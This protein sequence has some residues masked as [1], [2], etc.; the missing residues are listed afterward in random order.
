MPR[1]QII[2]EQKILPQKLQRARELR[3]EMTPEERLLWEAVRRNQLG[4]HFRRQQII[5]GF[6][7]DFYCHAA[8]LV[9]EVDGAV[10]KKIDQRDSD[11]ARERVLREAGLRVVR[12]KNRAIRR[13][14]QSVISQ[15]RRRIREKD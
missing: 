7:V 10:H 4:V 9:I 11:A 14:L 12:F 1:R 13:D 6:I 5:Q 8:R 3:K 15:I 2:T